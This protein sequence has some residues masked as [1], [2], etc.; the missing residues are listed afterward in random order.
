[1]T[2]LQEH[3]DHHIDFISE[4]DVGL[5]IY[6]L[7]GFGSIFENFGMY[8]EDPPVIGVVLNI[9]PAYTNFFSEEELDKVDMGVIERHYDVTDAGDE[10]ENSTLGVYGNFHPDTPLGDALGALFD[11]A[12]PLIQDLV[13]GKFEDVV[14]KAMEVRG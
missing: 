2:T 1:M 6:G 13:T 3:I 7:Q 4:D 14:R 9:Y 5:D 10:W 11:K 12:Q 8:D